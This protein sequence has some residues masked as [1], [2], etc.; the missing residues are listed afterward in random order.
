MLITIYISK[1]NFFVFNWC[2]DILDVLALQPHLTYDEII[3][4]AKKQYLSKPKLG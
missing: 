3:E 4:E 2:Y 1:N